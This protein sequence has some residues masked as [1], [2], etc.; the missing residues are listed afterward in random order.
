M[1]GYFCVAPRTMFFTAS[2]SS[3][4]KTYNHCWFW[5]LCLTDSAE[6]ERIFYILESLKLQRSS[7]ALD[8]EPA[9]FLE[10]TKGYYQM[11]SGH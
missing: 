10:A 2:P 1:T 4:A 11:V 7:L 6:K 3:S 5:F 8:F 9:P